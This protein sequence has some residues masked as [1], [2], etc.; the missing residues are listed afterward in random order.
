M[1]LSAYVA[2]CL[3]VEFGCDLGGLRRG[4]CI[5]SPPPSN[6]TAPTI[7]THP[8]NKTVAPGADRDLLR[9][10]DGQHSFDLPVAEGPGSNFRCDLGQ[11]HHASSIRDA[12][13]APSS[14]WW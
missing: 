1:R 11:L 5:Y 7:T 12:T 10:R 8:A 9:D 3:C 4:H 6:D 13:T 2:V 14:G